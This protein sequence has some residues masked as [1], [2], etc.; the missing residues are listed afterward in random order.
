MRCHRPRPTM[1]AVPAATLISSSSSRLFWTEVEAYPA[2]EAGHDF[3]HAGVDFPMVGVDV[4]VGLHMEGHQLPA[5]PL[6][7]EHLRLGV[8]LAALV[9]A[10]KIREAIDRSGS[11]AEMSFPR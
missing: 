5:V 8:R 3:V 9:K 1:T 7:V 2:G 10:D 11:H 4:G 6:G